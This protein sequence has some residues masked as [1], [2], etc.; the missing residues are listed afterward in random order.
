M[1]RASWAKTLVGAAKRVET[2]N[3]NDALRAV[4]PEVR[5]EIR[6][7]GKLGWISAE[8]MASLMNSIERAFGDHA[9]TV[10]SDA[11]RLAVDSPL[12]RPL[13]VGAFSLFGNDPLKIVKMAPRVWDLLT[14]HCGTFEYAAQDGGARLSLHSL[15]PPLRGCPAFVAG[16]AGAGVAMVTLCGAVPRSQTH[17]EELERGRAHIDVRW[18]SG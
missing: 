4:A 15:A 11:M 6:A 2:P 12:L 9:P 7:K 10:W 5:A 16:I 13:Q 18:S 8:Q 3:R 14:R 1:V 17:T